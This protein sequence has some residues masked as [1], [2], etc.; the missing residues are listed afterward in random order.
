LYGDRGAAQIIRFGTT[1]RGEF[2]R[3]TLI[4]LDTRR[5]VGRG[6]G[7]TETEAS[8][9]LLQQLKRRG[10]ADV[11][12]PLVSDGWGSHR[13]ALIE[14]YGQVPDY[15]GRE[16]PPSL[17]QPSQ[18]WQYLQMVKPRENG[19]VFRRRIRSNGTIQVDKHVYYVDHRLDKRSVLVHLDAHQR[20]LRVTLDGKLLPKA[21][22]L[23][24]LHDEPHNPTASPKCA[25]PPSAR[26]LACSSPVTPWIWCF[27]SPK[28]LRNQLSALLIPSQVR[29]AL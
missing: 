6:I 12:P 20:C 4:E 29:S 7:T 23:K 15:S 2:W 27:R 14:V 17:K 11:P 10:H 3:C 9:E 16:R 26:E 19:R 21:L 24:G 5:R 8:I 13:E 1:R 28:L 25:V 18:D 22:S